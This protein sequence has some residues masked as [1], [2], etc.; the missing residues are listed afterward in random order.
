MKKVKFTTKI[1]TIEAN[2]YDQE[3]KAG[4]KEN[5]RITK[6]KVYNNRD[7]Y[8]AYDYDKAYNLDRLMPGPLQVII[9]SIMEESNSIGIDI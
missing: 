5:K 7:R 4:M 8:M 9:E 1:Y 3:H 6:L 2:V